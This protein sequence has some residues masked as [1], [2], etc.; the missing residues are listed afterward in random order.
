MPSGFEDRINRTKERESHISFELYRLLRN[1]ISAGLTYSDSNCEFKDVLPEFPIGKGRA[2]LIVF[3]VKAYSHIEPYLV[4]EVK[5]R[6]Y[7][8]PGPSVASAVKKAASYAT[9]LGATIKPFYAVY[10]G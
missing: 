5:V 10:D 9:D 6:A 1:T 4:I 2:D 7:E 3:A 8:R